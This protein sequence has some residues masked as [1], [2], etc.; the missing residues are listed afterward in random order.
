MQRMLDVDLG[1]FSLDFNDNDDVEPFPPGS[2]PNVATPHFRMQNVSGGDLVDRNW[3]L[4]TQLIKMFDFMNVTVNYIGTDV[5]LRLDPTV[6]PWAIIQFGNFFYPAVALGSLGQD[7]VS[8]E[9]DVPLNV[10]GPLIE[11]LTAGNVFRGFVPPTIQ[12]GS[13]FTLIPEPGAAVLLA[14]GLLGLAA[15]GRRLGRQTS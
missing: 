3:V 8:F 14:G 2:G 9:F 12:M 5:A 15:L 4:I 11:V 6:D 1:I 10:S 13:A 7:D